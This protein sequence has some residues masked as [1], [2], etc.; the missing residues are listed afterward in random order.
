MKKLLLI[1]LVSATAWSLLGFIR[2]SKDEAAQL[3]PLAPAELGKAQ[4]VVRKAFADYEQNGEKALKEHWAYPIYEPEFNSSTELMN[5][6]GEL[7][8]I[9]PGRAVHPKFNPKSLLMDAKVGGRNIQISLTIDEYGYAI[10]S[11]R[12]RGR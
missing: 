2:G 8:A 6:L 9:T 10:E 7:K 11:V 12:E 1:I 3:V 4:N 5:K